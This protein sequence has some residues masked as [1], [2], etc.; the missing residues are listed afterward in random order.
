[1]FQNVFLAI[2]VDAYAGV[3]ALQRNKPRRK[4]V[5]DY[6]LKMMD[7]LKRSRL[8]KFFAPKKDDISTMKEMLSKL[9]YNKLFVRL[10]LA[11]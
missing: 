7:K 3:K 2:I 4:H 11:I 1:M 6:F 10:L 8:V 9:A 5:P